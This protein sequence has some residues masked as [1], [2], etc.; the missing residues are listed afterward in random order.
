[1]RSFNQIAD[2]IMNEEQ[3]TKSPA[4][5]IKSQNLSF[6]SYNIT[7]EDGY[8][9]SLWHVW[10]PLKIDNSSTPVFMQ[11]GLIDIAG[12][13]FFNEPLKS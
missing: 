8:I 12:T 13:W 11:H 3:Y 7:T 6:E 2:S 10:N 5:Q 4:D 1:M 9:L